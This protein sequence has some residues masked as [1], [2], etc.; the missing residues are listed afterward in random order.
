MKN[1]KIKHFLSSAVLF[2]TMMTAAVLCCTAAEESEFSS[3]FSTEQADSTDSVPE[4]GSSAMNIDLED[5]KYSIQ[6][7]CT[8]GSGKAGVSS[9]A[10]LIVE[11]GKAYARLQW[12]SEN[13]D[14]MIVD[15]E[16]YLNERTDGGNSEFTVPILA[17]DTPLVYIADTTAMGTPHEIEYTFTFYSESI[18]S[19]GNLP[20]EAA[21]KVAAIA[22]AIIVIGGILNYFVKKRGFGHDC[23]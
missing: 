4:S 2:V 1:N 18:G 20:Q 12:S 21:K 10:L 16:T 14:Y 23:G 7:D 22:I 5:G 8:G 13:Y 3:E 19:K 6:V 11:N 9:P 17:I 15:G